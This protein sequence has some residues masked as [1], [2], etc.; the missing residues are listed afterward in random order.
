[1]TQPRDDATRQA[2]ERLGA[3]LRRVRQAA[4]VTTRQ[5]PKA[6]GSE[7]FYTSAHIS[8]VESGA[9]APSLD[10]IE[11]YVRIGG[12]SAEL[13]S[14]YHQ[15]EAAATAA[16]RRRRLGD[17]T[18][19]PLPP[20]DGASV[21]DR[22]E[23]QRHYVVVAQEMHYRFNP[24]GSIQD[25]RAL[26]RVRAKSPAVRLCYVGFIYPADQRPGVLSIEP[27]DG[28]TLDHLRESETGMI[29]AFLKL[30]RDLYPDEPEPFAFSFRLDVDSANRALPRL[31]YFADAG[32]ERLVLSAEFLPEA[33]PK[34]LWWFGARDIVEVENRRP[35]HALMHDGNGLYERTFDELVPTWCYGFA[36]SW[37]APQ[38]T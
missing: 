4:G 27:G 36:W 35:G 29:A 21:E 7:T 30:D 38:G 25:C 22:D 20:R 12:D 8:L 26:V 24:D 5:V 15:A 37:D 17:S 3:A 13:R 14:L 16:D 28:V 10:L 19:E 2:R 18:P 31:R 1:M 33:E 32:T 23:V 34:D 6:G 9:T 11:G